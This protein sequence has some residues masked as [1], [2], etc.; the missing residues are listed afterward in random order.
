MRGELEGVLRTE[1]G[2]THTTLQVDHTPVDRAHAED[3]SP[4]E[5]GRRAMRVLARRH[6]AG[7]PDDDHCHAAHGPV[8]RAMSG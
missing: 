3:V 8:H 5:V 7:A 2:I 4:A 1:Y 6:T